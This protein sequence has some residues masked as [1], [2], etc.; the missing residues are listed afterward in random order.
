MVKKILLLSNHHAYTYNFRKEI[1]QSLLDDGYKVTVVAPYGEKIEL[2]KEM[3][4]DY[5]DLSLDRRG[6]NLKNDIQLMYGYYKIVRRIKP[7]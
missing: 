1:I 5:I 7:D 4:C 2:L 3:G 6:I